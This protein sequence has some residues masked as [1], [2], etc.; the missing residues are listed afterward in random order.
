MQLRSKVQSQC[1]EPGPGVQV[2]SWRVWESERD[3]VGRS[4]SAKLQ[5]I[6]ENVAVAVAVAVHPKFLSM[7]VLRYADELLSLPVRLGLLWAA[8]ETRLGRP[9]PLF[10]VVFQEATRVFYEVGEDTRSVQD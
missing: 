6:N 3:G 7:T 1:A 4:F 2:Q 8:G 5:F 9:Q 10:C